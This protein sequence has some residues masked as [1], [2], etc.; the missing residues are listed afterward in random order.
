MKIFM[1]LLTQNQQEIG[2]NLFIKIF[3]GLLT[4]KSTRN[5]VFFI[6]IFKALLTQ[7]QEMGSYLLIKIFIALFKKKSTRKRGLI[8]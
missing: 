5:G 4:K 1:A 6:K 8:Y 3:I 7:N 2:S